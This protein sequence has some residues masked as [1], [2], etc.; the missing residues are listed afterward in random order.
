MS[1]S[2]TPENRPDESLAGSLVPPAPVPLKSLADL[3]S[4]EVPILKTIE[5]TRHGA[6]L[7]LADPVRFLREHGFP[8]TPEAEAELR[9][10]LPAVEKTPIALYDGI[11]EGR[12][13]LGSTE[14]L[15][16][17]YHIRSLAI[18]HREGGN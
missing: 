1:T 6:E 10:T 5:A 12:A 16:A 15:R 2:Q 14:T 9:R 4:H 11:R 3:Q 18:P 17:R 13:S 7:F 8:L